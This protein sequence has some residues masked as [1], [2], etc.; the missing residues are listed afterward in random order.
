MTK[1]GPSG[2]FNRP[3]FAVSE[4]NQPHGSVDLAKI[5]ESSLHPRFR[6]LSMVTRISIWQVNNPARLR[7]QFEQKRDA[8][9]AFA[10]VLSCQIAWMPNGNGI[11]FTVF[12]SESAA[13]AFDEL[14]IFTNTDDLISSPSTTAYPEFVALK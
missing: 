6:A 2:A 13:A 9:A 3:A 4:R 8:I 12:S 5:I 7:A 10:G 11:T 1:A 14:S